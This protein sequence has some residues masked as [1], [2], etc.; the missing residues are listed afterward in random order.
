MVLPAV[1]S[2][3]WRMPFLVGAGF[4]FAIFTSY[5]V[6]GEFAHWVAAGVLVLGALPYAWR[7]VRDI[8]KGQLGVDLISL[9]AIF[10]SLAF[11]QLISGGIILFML[12]GGEALE[13]YALAR[14][15]SQLTRLLS[16]A[17]SVAHR[18]RNGRIRDIKVDEIGLEDELLVK[19]GE[20]VP[21]D[22]VIL[23]GMALIDE[24]MVTG[25]PLP[26]EKSVGGIAVSGTVNAG[27]AF[28]MRATRLSR[29][30]NYQKIVALVQA[31]ESNRA[32]IVRVAD[33]YSAGF[34]VLTFSLAAFAWAASRDPLFAYAVLVVATP[35]PLIIATPTA[36]MSGISVAATRGIVVKNG[37]ALETLDR[38]KA[39]VFDKTGTITFGQPSVANVHGYTMLRDEVIR[40]AASLDQVS[41]H[42]LARSLI[43]DATQRGI[44][45]DMP[46]NAH[47]TVAQGIT[48]EIDGDAY[49]LGK[50]DFLEAHGITL[51]EEVR[52][53]H[54]TAQ[55][56]GQKM[57]FLGHGK[58]VLGSITFAD[59]LRPDTKLVFDA[60]THDGLDRI[61][62]LS[63]DKSD[64]VK[65]IGKELGV[66]QA[67]GDLS[68]QDK[69][70]EIKKLRRSVEPVVM[71]G[72]GVNDAPALAAADI[73]IA[74][75]SHGMTASSETADVV[76]TVDTLSRV[77]EAFAISRHTLRVAKQGIFFGMG[78]SIVLM[79]F[80]AM[81][82][83][84]PVVGAFIQEGL[85]AVVIINALRVYRFKPKALRA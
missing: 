39:I 36:I 82:M 20:T 74:M 38:A 17:P 25:E 11:G 80:A 14:A 44:A 83:I 9:V 75:G 21:T 51:S 81:G 27:D 58:M 73:G 29:D 42:I 72:D 35:C 22:G 54:R 85:D 23:R 2:S 18:K 46:T 6:S 70:R 30:S 10:A 32:P 61:M 34:T 71:V 33:R 65:R 63:G 78:V 77:Q 66:K 4:A 47:E 37:G 69:V 62:L 68:P 24:S 76:I 53:T 67:F 1:R 28:W 59:T 64:V 45:L 7:M 41:A 55:R 19:A 57:V 8:V 26:V 5:A 43:A 49:V 84:P 56:R 52:A 13:E 15:R 60:F 16:R 12:A 48:G 79:L 50:Q 40:I 31:A 3:A